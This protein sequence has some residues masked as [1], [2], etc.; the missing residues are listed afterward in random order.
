MET[1]KIIDEV[2][3]LPVEE[4]ALIADSI[5]RSLNAVE[6]DIDSKWINEAKERLNELKSGKIKTIPGAEVFYKIWQR[7]SS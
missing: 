5:L 7:F 4:R 6:S 1:K 2:N 3:S